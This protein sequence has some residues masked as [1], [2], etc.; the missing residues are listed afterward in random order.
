[1]NRATLTV[2]TSCMVSIVETYREELEQKTTHTQEQKE[3]ADLSIALCTTTVTHTHH[4]TSEDNVTV[5]Q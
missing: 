1:M 4:P 2:F 3:I 5:H